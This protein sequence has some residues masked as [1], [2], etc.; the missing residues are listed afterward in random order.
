MTLYKNFLL[1]RGVGLFSRVGLISGDYGTSIKA[2]RHLENY[3]LEHLE[4]CLY[5]NVIFKNMTLID[6]SMTVH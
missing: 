4:H 2:F 6:Q 3:I 1:K 5:H